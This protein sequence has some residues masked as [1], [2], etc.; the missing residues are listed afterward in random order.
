M[1][2]IAPMARSRKN[3]AKRRPIR[4][5]SSGNDQPPVTVPAVVPLAAVPGGAAVVDAAVGLDEVLVLPVGEPVAS[6]DEPVVPG[7]PV[8][9]AP[10]VVLPVVV[11]PV[12]VL[13]VVVA[14]VA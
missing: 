14:P 10:V 11:L 3:P 7:T 9:G 5:C 12:V 2:R 13:G 4:R 1:V 8:P 6:A